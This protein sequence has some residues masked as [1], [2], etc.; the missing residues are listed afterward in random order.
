M[1][2]LQKQVLE[3]HAVIRALA[4]LSVRERDAKEAALAE[5]E[6]LKRA[7]R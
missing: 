6:A 4:E 7:A 1:R 3:S 5:L 2:E